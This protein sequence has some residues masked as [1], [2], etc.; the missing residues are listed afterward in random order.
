MPRTSRARGRPRQRGRGREAGLGSALGLQARVVVLRVE[1]EPDLLRRLPAARSDAD[2]APLQEARDQARLHVKDVSNG[3]QGEVVT[4]SRWLCHAVEVLL[5]ALTHRKALILGL[6][7]PQLC[8]GP[9]SNR[10]MQLL[11]TKEL[12][13]HRSELASTIPSNLPCSQ[14]VVR[15]P[16]VKLAGCRVHLLFQR[17]PRR[18]RPRARVL[19]GQGQRAPGLRHALGADLPR[20]HL[21]GRRWILLSP[22]LRLKRGGYRCIHLLSL[23]L[24]VPILGL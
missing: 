22:R 23:D 3:L 7:G 18:R 15:Q 24:M 4:P 2:E 17:Q 20:L 6:V 11:V 19:Q 1:A 12:I 14:A 8:K 5:K 13:C 16:P 21:Q 9:L 10:A